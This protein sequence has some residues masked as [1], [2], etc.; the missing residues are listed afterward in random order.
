MPIDPV[1]GLCNA[2][3]R[4][5]SSIRSHFATLVC[6]QVILA[7]LV[8]LLMGPASSHE[9]DGYFPNIVE[10]LS[11]DSA[12]NDE[13][14]PVDPTKLSQPVIEWPLARRSRRHFGKE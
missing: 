12:F 7:A 9:L 2:K 14:L 8:I 1:S 3:S 13:V 4:L 5:R 10:L 11:V 6:G